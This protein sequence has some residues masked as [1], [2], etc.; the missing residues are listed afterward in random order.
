M[1]KTTGYFSFL[2]RRIT[3]IALFLYVFTHIWVIGSVL[4]GEQAFNQTMDVLTAPW[5][6]IGE[7]GLLAAVFYHGLDG[8]RLLIVQ[9]FKVTD[10]RKSMLLAALILTTLMVI[11]GGVP[12][13]LEIINKA[14]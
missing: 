12:I 4:R 8:V 3:G 2:L 10:W 6:K 14:G 13:L 9:W 7:I 1:H 11:I 5:F